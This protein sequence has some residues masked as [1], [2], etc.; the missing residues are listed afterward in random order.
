MTDYSHLRQC[1]THN[2]FATSLQREHGRRECRK[3][4][5][6][7]ILC[8]SASLT[9]KQ[10]KQWRILHF[11]KQYPISVSDKMAACPLFTTHCRYPH[12]KRPIR[13]QLDKHPY[14]E[15]YCRQPSTGAYGTIETNRPNR[16]RTL[17][18]R[19]FDSVP[20]AGWNVKCDEKSK[21][22]NGP[23]TEFYTLIYCNVC[24]TH[25][26]DKTMDNLLV[27]I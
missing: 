19:N 5:L 21:S 22:K 23:R 10:N 13:K 20:T 1:L 8:F 24:D 17:N 3:S 2:I 14:F 26:V 7:F 9:S 27:H 4:Q 11:R 25:C 16:T 12:D 18:A 6:I 15:I